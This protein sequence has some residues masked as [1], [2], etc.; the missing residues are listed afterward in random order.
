M[1]V[2]KPA[3]IFKT[4]TF[5]YSKTFAILIPKD[6]VSLNLQPFKNTSAV[7]GVT[8]GDLVLMSKHILA[9]QLLLNNWQL[10]AADVNNNGT[11]TTADIVET[12]K[13]ILDLKKDFDKQLPWNL[14]VTNLNMSNMALGNNGSIKLFKPYQSNNIIDFQGIKIGDTNGSGY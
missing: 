10:V 11:I 12:R 6:A 7:S 5:S 13:I 4:D 1:T 14:R 9:T 2:E 8:T 3:N